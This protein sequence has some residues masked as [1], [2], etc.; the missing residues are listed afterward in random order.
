MDLVVTLGGQ[1][2]RLRMRPTPATLATLFAALSDEEQADFFEAVAR[3]FAAWG[4]VKAD[5]QVYFIAKHM[6]T[7]ACVTEAGRA[8]VQQLASYLAPRGASEEG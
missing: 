4:S 8:W 3:E 7:C 5:Q 1:E 6:R 2:S